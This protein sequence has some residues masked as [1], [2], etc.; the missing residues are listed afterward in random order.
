[1]QVTHSGHSLQVIPNLSLKDSDGHSALG[2]SLAVGSRLDIAELLLS[3]GANVN[4]T[5]GEGQ[6]LLFQAISRHDVDSAVFLL[7]H[8]A[9]PNAWLV[10][11]AD[12]VTYFV[13]KIF[14]ECEGLFWTLLDMY[15][16][17]AVL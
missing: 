14:K 12:Y 2:L 5:D 7:K 10:Y 13:M 9:D 6:T 8:Q 16:T 15:C 17:V 4:D 3:G 1:V 11:L